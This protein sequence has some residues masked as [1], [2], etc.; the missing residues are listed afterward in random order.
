MILGS[1]RRE[2]TVAFL[3]A[4]LLVMASVYVL[5]PFAWMLVT[6]FKTV[7]ESLRVPIT[8]LPEAPTLR[9]YVDM[10]TVKPF[11]QY[12]LS[13]TVISGATAILSSL[14]GSLA[15]YGLSRFPLRGKMVFLGGFLATQMISGV[16]VI[17]PYF[18]IMA[19]LGLYNTWTS[20]IIAF[21]T[22]CLPFST[23]MQKGYLDSIPM[24]LD[25][26]A[27]M[28]GASRL[29]I[30]WQVIL[31]LA[32]PGMVATTLF[33][34]LLAW[35]DLLWAATL[36]S[37]DD[38]RT[39]TQG[40]AFTVGEFITDWPM[41]S[42]ASTIGSVPSILLYVFMQRYLVGGITAGAVKQ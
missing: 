4:G 21:V 3:I 10:W 14:L 17:G 24:A 15:A 6:S 30:F 25:E 1:K 38:V 42:A 35:G 27:L 7:A 18:K 2:R 29:R 28:D 34:F 31:P 37:T 36:A 19:A 22:I 41:L 32:M 23:W 40:I 9:N 26:Q 39:V 13:S 33:G 20:L 16:L 5:V 8:W 12:F 11:G